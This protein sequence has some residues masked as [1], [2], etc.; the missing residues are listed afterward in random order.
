VDG[1]LLAAT[2]QKAVGEVINL[3]T[4]REIPIRDVV[5]KIHELTDSKSRLEIGA[6]PYRPTEIW[7]MCA[8]NRKARRLLDWSPTVSFEEGLKKSIEWYRA[9]ISEFYDPSS[10][11]RALARQAP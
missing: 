3:G 11:L 8:S 4:G 9:F 7:R 5:R 10:G 2:N 1:I 6:L